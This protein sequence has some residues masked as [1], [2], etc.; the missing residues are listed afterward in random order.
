MRIGQRRLD[1]STDLGNDDMTRE[2]LEPLVQRVCDRV[3]AVAGAKVIEG[4]AQLVYPS[5]S[6]ADTQSVLDWLEDELR[7]D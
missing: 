1:R 2:A 5:D 7:T 3:D 4:T 6:L